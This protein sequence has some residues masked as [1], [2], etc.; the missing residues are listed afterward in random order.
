MNTQINY[1]NLLSRVRQAFYLYVSD[2][3]V[4]PVDLNSENYFNTVNQ[5]KVMGYDEFI[6]QSYSGKNDL[7]TKLMGYKQTVDAINVDQ[8]FRLF[9]CQGCYNRVIHSM[10]VFEYSQYSYSALMEEVNKKVEEITGQGEVTAEVNLVT[11]FNAVKQTE[12]VVYLV[13]YSVRVNKF[14]VVYSKTEN[15]SVYLMTEEKTE[16]EWLTSSLKTSTSL[17]VVTINLHCVLDRFALMMKRFSI[18]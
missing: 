17:N 6:L 2:I 7:L 16:T 9:Y 12:N 10:A 15:K 1:Q 11:Y 8:A 4:V 5:L 18:F 13:K 3:E 14:S